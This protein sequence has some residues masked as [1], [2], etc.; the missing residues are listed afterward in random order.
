MQRGVH[1]RVLIDWDEREIRVR[2][3][4]PDAPRIAWALSFGHINRVSGVDAMAFVLASDQLVTAQIKAVDAKGNPARIDG[5]P[6]WASSD[7]GVVTVIATDGETAAIAAVGPV[8]TAQVQVTVD[9]DLGEGV[10]P[11]TGTLD[12]E[13]VASEAVAVTIVPGEPTTSAPTE[14]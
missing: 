9:A 6:V 1:T 8:G 14:A 3:I 13:V 7:E 12:V 2:D 5:A 10:R 11:L 4:G